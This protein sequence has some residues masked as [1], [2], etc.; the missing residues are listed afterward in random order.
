MFLFIHCLCQVVINL[1]FDFDVSLFILSMWI[2][3]ICYFDCSHVKHVD[4]YH[5]LFWSA[6]V[7]DC[8][9][10]VFKVETF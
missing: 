5:K 9:S 10:R 8:V 6:R 3:I 1:M 4:Y 2:T 7:R